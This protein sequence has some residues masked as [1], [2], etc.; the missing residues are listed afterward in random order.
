MSIEI[1]LGNS[2]KKVNSTLRPSGLTSFTCNIKSPSSII[3]PII[4]INY[5]AW[6]I[7]GDDDRMTAYNYAYIPVFN[8][9]YFIND[10]TFDRGLWILSLNADVLA[11]FKTQI[12]DDTMYI[13]RSSADSDGNIIDEYYPATGEVTITDSSAVLGYNFNGFENGQ[14]V[15]GVL[16]QEN[17]TD[18]GVIYYL[19][20]PT[21]FGVMIHNFYSSGGSWGSLASGVINSLKKIDQYIVSVYWYPD[22]INI[23]NDGGSNK[24]YLG[25]Y[26]TGITAAKVTSYTTTTT[27]TW[28]SIPKHPQAWDRGEYLNLSPFSTYKLGNFLTG[29][30]DIPAELLK[31]YSYFRA[32][33]FVDLTSGKARIAIQV[34][35]DTSGSGS[36]KVIYFTYVDFGI[37][38]DI[39]A[40]TVDTGGIFNSVIS[41]ATS[42]VTGNWLGVAGSIGNAAMSAVP[43]PG[44]AVIGDSIIAINDSSFMLRGIFKNIVD[45]DNLNHGK[46]LCIKG[47]ISDYPGYLMINEPHFSSSR[48]T[49]N[50]KDMVN[51]YLANGFYYE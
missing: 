34:T 4:E 16:G 48:A 15:V 3:N 10:V 39:G 49:Q 29:T 42:L 44:H 14:Y 47:L 40:V 50:E 2:D 9:Y 27:T 36:I 35:N 25:N 12:G 38:V 23:P 8:R 21:D 46:P 19:L 1:Q 31:N 11:T 32:V 18:D 24:L 26:N 37:S 33:L 51:S 17:V 28:T 7:S 30:V 45:N 20:D 41:G 5:P 22:S 13:L 43:T 6:N